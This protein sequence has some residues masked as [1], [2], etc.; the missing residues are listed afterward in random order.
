MDRYPRQ[1][2]FTL[3][4]L[5]VVITLLGITAAI[6]V[7]SFSRLIENNRR[8]TVTNDM[9]GLLSSA[10]SEA[11]RRRAGVIVYERTD[12]GYAVC[13]ASAVTACKNGTANAEQLLRTTNDLPGSTSLSTV[14]DL[15]FNGRGMASASVTYQLCVKAG[16]EAVEITVNAGG[17]I[18][19]NDN[20][21]VTCS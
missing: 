19:T 2:G 15:T 4:E 17:Q 11:I 14:S 12:G 7:P 8:A 3:I 13:L 20:S 16:T 21:G 9:A 10:R 5:L 6:A 1:R 18:R